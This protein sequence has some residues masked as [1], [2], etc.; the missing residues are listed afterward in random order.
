[1]EQTGL[2]KHLSE[3]KDTFVSPLVLALHGELR[4][5]REPEYDLMTSLLLTSANSLLESLER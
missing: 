5:Q 1:M 3:I 2:D 4:Q